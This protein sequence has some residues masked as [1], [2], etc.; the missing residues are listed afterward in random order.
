MSIGQGA[1]VLDKTLKER[2]EA[3]AIDRPG[4]QAPDKTLKD[5]TEAFTHLV[6]QGAIVLD[7]TLQERTNALATSIGQGADM[8]EQDARPTAPVSSTP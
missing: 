5:R 3:L 4:A 1:Q 7:K 8:L 6:S 2:T